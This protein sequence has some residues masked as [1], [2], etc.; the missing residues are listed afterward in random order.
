MFTFY[1]GF[2]A[3]IVPVQSVKYPGPVQAA[4]D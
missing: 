3:K 2:V 1:Q 4:F